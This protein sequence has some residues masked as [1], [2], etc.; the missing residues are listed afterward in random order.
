M[1][2]PKTR[3]E[4]ASTGIQGL[5]SFIGGGLPRNRVYLIEG[6]PGVGKTTLGFRFLLEGAKQKENVLLVSLAETPDEMQSVAES[7]GWDLSGITIFNL[8]PSL[9]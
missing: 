2:T 9:Y 6:D 7:H 1:K 3:P 8:A 5:D 4:I